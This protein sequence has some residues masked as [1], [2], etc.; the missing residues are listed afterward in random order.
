MKLKK[1]GLLFLFSF[2]FVSI[3]NSQSFEDYQ[4]KHQNQIDLLLQDQNEEIDLLQKNYADFVKKHDQ[5]WGD[6]LKK[7]WGKY[8]VFTG[9][10]IPKKPEPENIPTYLPPSIPV[11]PQS[12]SP[13][14][15]PIIIPEEFISKPIPPSVKPVCKPAEEE[16]TSNS[17][18]FNFYGRNFSFPYDDLMQ[19]AALSSINQQGITD[20]WEKLSACN[21]T[22]AVE[23]LL[24]AKTS[25]KINDY[26]YFLL[27]EQFSEKLY[28]NDINVSRLLT[29]FIMVRSGYGIRVAFQ[30]SK[31]VLLVPTLQQLYSVSYLT[32]GDKNYYIFPVSLKGSVSTY[33]KDYPS[34]VHLV[35]LNFRDAINFG[36]RNDIKTLSFKFEEKLYSIHVAYDPDLIEFWKEYPQVG[37]SVYFNAQT[38]IQ[39]KQ[40]L[41]D[42]LKPYTNQF[43]ELKAVN[44]LLHFVQTAFEYKRHEEQ[45]GR[46]K[47]FF[48][49]E[50]F[51]Y[52]FSDCEARSV[53][54]SYLVREIIGL[55]VIGLE[56]PG[57]MATAVGFTEHTPGDYLVFKNKNYVVSDPTYINAPVGLT[58]PQFKDVSPIVIEIDK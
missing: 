14:I 8:N 5:E 53:L 58:M 56:Y 15:K 22:P 42:A 55:K 9:K 28:P 48:A 11:L 26:G 52:P 37:Y 29:W 2:L 35:D 34:A 6:Y 3:G 20:F 38:S 25:L 7:E 40:S 18:S 39:A 57:H 21:Y 44:F 33:D 31:I 10:E 32:I 41:M 19:L 30:N 47:Y 51:Y 1:N 50:L 16:I 54:F 23:R 45:F 43:D 13:E 49:E 27:V 46:E 24:N 36:G 12:N 4:K 17:V